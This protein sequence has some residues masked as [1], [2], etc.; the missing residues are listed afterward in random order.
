MFHLEYLRFARANAGQLYLKIFLVGQ[1]YDHKSFMFYFFIPSVLN[2]H[3]YSIPNSLGHRDSLGSTS[4]RTS[5]VH[6][7]L[8]FL[9]LQ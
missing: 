2:Q 6:E 9:S 3:S 5:Q 7:G 8:N 1:T 4:D